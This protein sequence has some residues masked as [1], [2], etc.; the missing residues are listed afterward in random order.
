MTREFTMSQK[1]KHPSASLLFWHF[2]QKHKPSY[3][4]TASYT[5]QRSTQAAQKLFVSAEIQGGC[6]SVEWRRH[7]VFAHKSKPRARMHR[8]D[9]RFA[10]F[11]AGSA[12]G[13]V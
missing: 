7:I 11:S 1:N 13:D 2:V 4:K 5:Y 8:P 12:Q 6:L 10:P 3:S 9:T